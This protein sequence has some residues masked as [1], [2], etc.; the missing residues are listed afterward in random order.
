[1]DAG[2][3]FLFYQKT[4]EDVGPTPVP[5]HLEVRYSDASL[6]FPRKLTFFCYHS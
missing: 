3:T 6:L 1:M 5:A 4:D 2:S